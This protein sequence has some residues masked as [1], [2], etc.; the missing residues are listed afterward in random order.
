VVKKEIQEAVNRVVESGSYVLGSELSAF[1]REFADYCGTK[2]CVGVGS[3]TEALTL[4]LRGLGIGYGDEVICP[5]FTFVATAEAI[6]NVGAKPVFVDVDPTNFLIDPSLIEQ[7]ITPSTMAII[8]VHLYGQTAPMDEIREI[9]DKFSLVVVEDACQAHGGFCGDKRVGS[10]GDA[11]CF[12]FYPSKNLG[13][14]GDGGAIVTQD[15]G[16]ALAIRALRNHGL[17]DTEHMVVGF[18]SR[19]DEIQA[20]ILREKL[21]V[22]EEFNGQRQAIACEYDQLLGSFAMPSCERG[23]VYHLYDWRSNSLS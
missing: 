7:A 15:A 21:W 18:N 10:I 1:E 2:Y 20:A 23:S 14:Y 4:A 17:L 11:G 12:S 8:P 5:A 19:L 9:A 22:L 6:R 13:C 3:G 16:L